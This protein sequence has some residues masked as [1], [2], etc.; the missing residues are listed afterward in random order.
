MTE[1]LQRLERYLTGRI[2]DG[3][4]LA[5]GEAGG[6]TDS[7]LGSQV[8]FG[9]RGCYDKIRIFIFILFGLS[10]DLFYNT[11]F[12]FSSW[13]LSTDH[14]LCSRGCIEISSSASYA[15]LIIPILFSA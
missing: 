6:L 14:H 9:L 15:E 5:L 1:K 10:I 8:L 2:F 4:K 12:C 13:T 7:G 11:E 3:H